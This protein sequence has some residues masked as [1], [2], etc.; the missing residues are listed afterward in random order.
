MPRLSVLAALGLLVAQGT[1]ISVKRV[2]RLAPRRFDSSVPFYDHDSHAPSDCTLWWN[3]DDGLSC[4]TVLIIAGISAA[5][6]TAL[7]P[8][9]KTCGDWKVDYSYCIESASGFPE[10]PTP[11]TPTTTTSKAPATTPSP[12]TPANGVTTPDPAQPGMVDNCNRFYKVVAGDTCTTIASK[13]G[14]TIAQ[15]A[16]WNTQIGGTAC[17]GIWAEYY[18]C[19]GIIG[20][21]PTQPSPT[22]TPNPTPQPIQDGMVDN[23]NRWHLVKTGD[24]CS[25]IASSVGVTVAQLAT[26]NKGI[27]G[28]ACTGMWAGYYLCTG[29]S[30]GSG[31][32]PPPANTTPQPIQDGMVSNC[33]KFHFVLGGQNCDSISKQ[34]GITVANFIKWNPAAGA[35]CTGLWA[36]TYACVGL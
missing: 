10:P 16:A 12:T 32:T 30:G 23:C 8:S 17:T 14:V 6:L 19:T 35:S 28:T 3:S 11:P 13:N 2:D 9:I 36:S 22:A 1:A 24:T 26:W 4:D 34:Y 29:V 18:I 21:S 25:T 7:N 20:G 15:L 5:Q 33:K 31:T 27:G